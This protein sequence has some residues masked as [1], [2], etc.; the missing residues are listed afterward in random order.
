MI[1]CYSGFGD[2]GEDTGMNQML[3]DKNIKTVYC[4]GLAFD[5]CVGSTAV[6]A[7]QAGYSTFIFSDAT[8]SVAPETEAT[9]QKKVEENNI[10]MIKVS[11]F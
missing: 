11:E 2:Y 7:A 3:K 9:M 1:E 5:Y 6:S 8:K 4:C 10:K